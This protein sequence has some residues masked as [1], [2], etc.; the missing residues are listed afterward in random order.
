MKTC[1]HCG[2][3]GVK[4]RTTCSALCLKNF[5]AELARRT[6]AKAT[7]KPA[8]KCL[9]CNCD[10]QGR[11]KVCGARCLNEFRSKL[12][13][14]T[15]AFKVI[16]LCIQCNSKVYFNP[17]VSKY[18]QRKTCSDTCYENFQKKQL[19]E[20]GRPYRIKMML[21]QRQQEKLAADKALARR[22]QEARQPVGSLI[23]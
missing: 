15:I 17:L 5:R 20:A 9:N 4:N 13:R 12:A 19:V 3:P 21:L 2:G 6:I 16:G 11:N 23:R 7:A 8:R 18:K 22:L 1:V 10:L 14:R